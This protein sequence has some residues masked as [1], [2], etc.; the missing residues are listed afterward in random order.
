MGAHHTDE[1][2]G[3]SY[4]LP[5]ERAYCETCAAVAS[6]MLSWRLL[7]ATGKVRYADLIERTLHNGLLVGISCSGDRYTYVNPLQV[8]DDHPACGGGIEPART[9]WFRCACCPPNVMRLLA[10]LQHYVVPGNETVL[11][12]HQCLSGDF[13]S[14]TSVGTVG[15]SVESALPWSGSVKVTVTQST[16]EPWVLV[17]RVPQWTERFHLSLEGMVLDETPQEGWLRIT[18]RWRIGDSLNF[19]PEMPPR[20][21]RPDSRVDAAR[22]CVA[23]E[24]G[25]LIYYLEQ[26]D[27]DGFR[28]DDVSLDVDAPR[29]RVRPARSAR[30][31]RPTPRRR[32]SPPTTTYYAWGNRQTGAMRVWSPRA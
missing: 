13:T 14:R 12:V 25:P 31:H 20:L 6:V 3:D 17:L 11:V 26:V 23:I 15:V 8:R 27:Q 9:P 18:R 2:F 19:E 10:S 22:G 1:A 21:T 16:R 5:N 32:A 24:R 7:L 4:E 30:R 28:L 29:H